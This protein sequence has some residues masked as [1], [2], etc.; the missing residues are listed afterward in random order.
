MTGALTGPRMCDRQC[1]PGVARRQMRA[2]A[3]SHA[4]NLPQLSL[5]ARVMG[6]DT[7]GRG[8]GREEKEARVRR[9]TG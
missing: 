3:S 8:R 1:V 6:V 7:G 2:L 9:G 4:R 5:E